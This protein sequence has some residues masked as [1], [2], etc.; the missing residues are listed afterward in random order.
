MSLGVSTRLGSYEILSALGAGGM[1]EAYRARDTK[2]DRDVALSWVN[3]VRE[4]A[5][6]HLMPR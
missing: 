3:P 6:S 1:G 5:T 2:I 4:L